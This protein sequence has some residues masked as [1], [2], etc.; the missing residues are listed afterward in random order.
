MSCTFFNCNLSSYS[1]NEKNYRCCMQFADSAG[2]LSNVAQFMYLQSMAGIVLPLFETFVVKNEL[3]PPEIAFSKLLKVVC[4]LLSTNVM[5]FLSKFI[6]IACCSSL[7]FAKLS[8][9][10]LK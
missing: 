6:D 10:E 7:T 9:K 8:Q 2:N 4:L 3:S 1:N 5:Q